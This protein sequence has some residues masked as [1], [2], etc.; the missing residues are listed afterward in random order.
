MCISDVKIHIELHVS[1]AKKLQT[2][3][4][5]ERNVEIWS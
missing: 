3:K 4:L 2:D 5:E 1:P